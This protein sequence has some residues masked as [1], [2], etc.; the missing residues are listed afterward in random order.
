MNPIFNAL[1]VF[2]SYSHDSQEHQERVLAFSDHLRSEGINCI[3]DQYEEDFPEG[4]PLWMEKQIRDADYVL[5][6]CTKPYYKRVM[7]EEEPGK[8]HG[9]RWEG[10]LIYQHLYSE[11]TFNKK[12]IPV[13]LETGKTE[14]IPTPLKGSIYYRVENK[15]EYEALYRRLTNQPL[16]PKLELGQLQQLPPRERKQFFFNG[17][18]NTSLRREL[19]SASQGLLNWPRTFGSNQQIARP[20]LE[21]LLSR[22]EEDEFST[23]LILGGPGSGKS[24]MLATLGHHLVDEEYAL[25]AIKADCLGNTVNTLEDLRHDDQVHLSMNPKDAIKAIANKERVVLLVDQLDAVSELLDRQPGRLNVLLNLI[26][27]LSGTRNVHIVATCREFEFR[28]S[29]QF[30]R[31]EHVDRLALSLPT[32]EQISPILLKAGH[33]PTIVGETLRELLRTPLH[34]KLFLEVAQPGEA[35]DSLQNLLGKLWEQRILYA[36]GAQKGIILL[37]RLARRMRDEEVLWLPASVADGYPEACKVLEQ[38]EILTRERGNLIGFRHQTYYDY[39]LARAFARGSESLADFVLERQDGL[40]VRPILLSSL[41]YLRGTARLQ[42]QQQLQTLLSNSKRDNCVLKN[43]VSKLAQKIL[44]HLPDETR[45]WVLGALRLLRLIYVRTHIY[46]LLIEFVGGQKD[47]DPVETSLLIPL[48][49]SETEGQRVLAAI[50]GSPGWFA[51]LRYRTELRQWLEDSPA[52]SAYCVPLLSTAV[53]FASEDVWN[54]IETCWLN[55]SAYDFLSIK[56]MLNSEQWTSEKVRLAER[57]IRRSNINWYDISAIAE[58]IAENFPELAPQILR[59]DLD[60]RLERAIEESNRPK[61][62]LPPDTDELQRYRHDADHDPLNPLKN[63]IEDESE[64][65]NMETFAETL[66]KFF[67]DAIW[68]WFLNV[69]ERIASEETLLWTSYRDDHLISVEFE[70]GTIVKALLIAIMRLA[71]RSPL[72]FLNFVQKNVYSELIA[73]HCLLA[74]GLE[75][76]AVQEPQQVLEYLL[77]DPRRLCLGDTWDRYRETKRL[78]AAVCPHLRPEDRIRIERAILVFNYYN[79]DPSEQPADFRFHC[80]KWNRRDRL[81]LLRAFPNDCLSAEAKQLKDV[82]ERALPETRDED[83]NYPTIAQVVGPRMRAEE[84]TRAADQHLLNLFNELSDATELAQLMRSRSDDF[85]RAG[86][87]GEQSG[88]FSKLVETNPER[89]VRFIQNLEPHR[90]E[91]YVGKAIEKLSETDFP[92][93]DLINLIESFDQ[94]GFASED[95]RHGASSALE[96]IARRNQNLPHK[97]LSLLECWLATHTK[98]D[99]SMYQKITESTAK[100]QKSPILFNRGGTHFLPQGRG[101]I[102]RA[103]AAGYLKQDPPDLDNWARV[104]RSRLDKEQHPA[105]WVEILAEMPPLLNGERIQATQL[106][107]AVIRKCPKVLHSEWA[108]YFISRT[109]GWFEPKE[110]VQGWLELLLAENS[111]FC[112]QVYGELL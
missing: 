35:F 25:L 63:L 18:Q 93:S 94:R 15:K 32:W 31:L 61:P 78:I 8:G 82:E 2:I 27:S 43:G 5:I 97:T 4:L 66:P 33:N 111:T 38:A 42:Y 75:R 80:L 68:P 84:M 36:E 98:P 10:N 24:A 53:Y 101:S 107:N 40:S 58:R 49:N 13:L 45:I 11:G 70:R 83:S 104:I 69:A 20:E 54:L 46:T 87:A 88:E 17:N 1:K 74:R 59:A 73:V 37:E 23:T 3:L 106:F 6:I 109:V 50:V 81:R 51:C 67:L 56:V 41:N 26:Q 14:D 76:I 55:D 85:S 100:Y 28:H 52:K 90:H 22:V 102:V 12:I 29:T 7:N 34:L 62:E 95:F 64:L 72:V 65:Y 105:I 60:R 47:P 57:V 77:G 16:T 19:L 99:L 71:A 108:L 30:S 39:T 103:I 21:Q 48:L 91:K 44:K 96:K 89:V 86:G 79:P 92:A 9:V 110:M 112:H